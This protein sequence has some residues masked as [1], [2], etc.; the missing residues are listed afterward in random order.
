MLLFSV[1]CNK[2]IQ[3]KR[4]QFAQSQ[5]VQSLQSECLHVCHSL[6]L[7]SMPDLLPWILF[8]LV[9]FS[10]IFLSFLF[11]KRLMQRGCILLFLLWFHFLKN[12]LYIYVCHASWKIYFI[13]LI[14]YVCFDCL[15]A[16]NFLYLSQSIFS[17][18]MPGR[19][20]KNFLIFNAIW[21]ACLSL[22]SEFRLCIF[23]VS[24]FLMSL[25]CLDETRRIF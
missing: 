11:S 5:S 9:L 22:F 6:L 19:D 24:V 3:T 23:I 15:H 10:R 25:L 8:V 14:I 4:K 20:K 1:D 2:I 17:I 16:C 21:F 18:S 13:C 12:R 7:V